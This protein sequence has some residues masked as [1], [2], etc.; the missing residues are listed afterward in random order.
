MKRTVKT[1]E[2]RPAPHILE[3]E[4]IDYYNQSFSF[5]VFGNDDPDLVTV[6]T[7][8]ETKTM[9]R[10]ALIEGYER[11]LKAIKEIPNASPS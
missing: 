4:T 9:A 7:T 1:F 11:L 2:D 5:T 8:G 3:S 6:T 10:A